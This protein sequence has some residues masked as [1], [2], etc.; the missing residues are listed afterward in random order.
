VRVHRRVPCSVA[1]SFG[2][3]RSAAPCQSPVTFPRGSLGVNVRYR[4]VVWGVRFALGGRRSILHVECLAAFNVGH[5]PFALRG[6]D[7]AYAVR[8]GASL[9][10][11]RCGASRSTLESSRPATQD[12]LVAADAIYRTYRSESV[13]TRLKPPETGMPFQRS[14]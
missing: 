1:G 2:V 9:E 10:L 7:F 12:L 4:A 13:T 8:P 5:R 14:C 3:L 6:G 11:L